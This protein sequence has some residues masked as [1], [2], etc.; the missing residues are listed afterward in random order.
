ML[1]GAVSKIGKQEGAGE[2][3]PLVVFVGIG[4]LCWNKSL[5]SSIN[6]SGSTQNRGGQAR[7]PVRLRSLYS[8]NWQGIL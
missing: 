8:Q 4:L 3:I 2:T 7:E 6:L 1:E 5:F